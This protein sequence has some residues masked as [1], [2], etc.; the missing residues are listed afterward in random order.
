M[1]SPCTEQPTKLENSNLLSLKLFQAMWNGS[2]RWAYTNAFA[3]MS[4]GQKIV[5][6]SREVGHAAVPSFMEAELNPDVPVPC[7]N[8]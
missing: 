3:P 4:E 7:F 8:H 2:H 5:L 1:L 6:L